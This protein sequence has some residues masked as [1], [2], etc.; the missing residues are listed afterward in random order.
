MNT[1]RRGLTAK[2]QQ[3]C[4]W[5][6]FCIRQVLAGV[7]GPC[8]HSVTRDHLLSLNR[9]I[10]NQLDHSCLIV[11]P[12]TECFNLSKVCCVKAAFPQVLELL[13]SHFHYIRTSDN[14]RYV[15]TLQTLIFHLYS[16][17]CLPEINEEFEDSPVWYLRTEQSSPKA[18][19]KKVRAVIEMYKSL[20]TESPGP[21]DWDCRGE[22]TAAD[23]PES[24]P[25]T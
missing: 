7:P 17:G 1:H 24:T 20:M 6:C 15:S 4:F 2:A 23:E 21:V 8:R 18:A 3:L 10:D 5:L 11:Y 12:F 9:L 22:Y 14:R 19:L 16:Q 13:S 25:G